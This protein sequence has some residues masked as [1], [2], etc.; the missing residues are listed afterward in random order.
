MAVTPHVT[1]AFSTVYVLVHD[2]L[3][4]GMGEEVHEVV[5]RGHTMG[6]ELMAP[7]TVPDSH[8]SAA[9]PAT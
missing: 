5:S 8:T 4:A 2:F 3:V 1:A 6:T 9:P 7:T